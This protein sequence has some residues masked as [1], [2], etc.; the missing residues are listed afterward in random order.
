MPLAS[1]LHS[2]IGFGNSL[3]SVQARAITQQARSPAIR[4][5]AASPDQAVS[6][7]AADSNLESVT[8]EAPSNGSSNGTG[9]ASPQ[10]ATEGNRCAASAWQLL[11]RL[12]PAAV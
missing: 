3:S 11:S 5:Y 4:V 8:S 1:H 6:D 2:L 10:S 12:Q 9:H 7:S